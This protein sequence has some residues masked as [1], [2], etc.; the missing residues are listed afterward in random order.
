M[1][2][3]ASKLGLLQKLTAFLGGFLI[4]FLFFTIFLKLVPNT[5]GAILG[6]IVNVGA[7][8]YIFKKHPKKTSGRIVGYGV[9]TSISAIVIL[10]IALWI[11]A[12]TLFQ[13]IKV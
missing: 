7:T 3:T 11:V 9:L 4:S 13:G 12:L 10:S 1:D 2:N 6:L 8:Y 5:W